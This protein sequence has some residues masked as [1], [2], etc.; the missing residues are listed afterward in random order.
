MTSLLSRYGDECIFYGT[1]MVSVIAIIPLLHSGELHDDIAETTMYNRMTSDSFEVA[2]YAS[3]AVAVPLLL[4]LANDITLR[5]MQVKQLISRAWLCF[6]LVFPSCLHVY[7][8]LSKKIV[9]ATW[10]IVNIRGVLMSSVVGELLKYRSRHIIPAKYFYMTH[11]LFSIGTVLKSY[12]IYSTALHVI[13]LIIRLVAWAMYISIIS[14]HLYIAVIRANAQD[15]FEKRQQ[16]AVHILTVIILFVNLCIMWYHRQHAA[17]QFEVEMLGIV[18]FVV[19]G[20]MLMVILFSIITSEY[21][22]D[23]AQ[24]QDKLSVKGMFVRHVSQEVRTPLNVCCLGIACMKKM[25]HSPT[26]EVVKEMR[27]I[28]DEVLQSC[29]SAISFMN[30]LLLYEKIDSKELPLYPAC[31]DL[32]VLCTKVFESLQASANQVGVNLSLD[33]HEVLVHTPSTPRRYPGTG[34][35]R[36]EVEQLSGAGKDH[37]AVDS[38]L[39]MSCPCSPQSQLMALISVDAPKLSIALSNMLANAIKYTPKGGNV[40]I[41]VLP[42]FD[43]AESNLDFN[44]KSHDNFY[45]Q[46]SQDRQL[47]KVSHIRVIIR[48]SGHGMTEGEQMKYFSKLV[49]FSLNDKYHKGSDI[50]MFLAHHIMKGHDLAMQVY[51]KAIKGGGT[52]YCVDFPLVRNDDTIPTSDIVVE[53]S[54]LDWLC[55]CNGFKKCL[56]K[57]RLSEPSRFADKNVAPEETSQA[58]SARLSMPMTTIKSSEGSCLEP[59]DWSNLSVLIVD[60]CPLNR[61]MLV[62]SLKQQKFGASH[63]CACDG[64]ELLSLFGVPETDDTSCRS[65]RSNVPMER[66]IKSDSSYDVILLDDNMTHMNGSTAVKRLRQSGYKGLVVG[67]TGSALEEDMQAFCR[68]GVDYAMPKPFVVSD[69]IKLM[70]SHT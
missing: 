8:S 32:T 30:N 27:V 58:P 16:L 35:D 40:S 48:G 37:P 21:R 15:W 22:H 41:S 25:I 66:T 26:K 34:G 5:K 42:V 39:N 50:G 52:H 53:E 31:E 62:R 57:S 7:Y 3:L 47:E 45:G 29:D 20:S 63:D 4:D 23:Y 2:V 6:A 9:Y 13:G 55:L 19:V 51:S 28:V 65:G 67:V 36:I 12:I 64:V 56:V 59:K 70:E 33:I 10:V 49:R 14:R 60:D 68:A 18:E 11:V 44:L 1:G 54:L 46:N 61:K 43:S 24:L 69:F 38:N 17:T